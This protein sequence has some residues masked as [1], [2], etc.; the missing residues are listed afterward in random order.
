MRCSIHDAAPTLPIFL[1]AR[2]AFHVSVH[3]FLHGSF[4]LLLVLLLHGEVAAHP[5]FRDLAVSAHVQTNFPRLF[6]FLVSFHELPMF[7]SVHNRSHFQ[8]GEGHEVP[9][10]HVARALFPFSVQSSSPARPDATG[11]QTHPR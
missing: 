3:S 5:P 2:I 1:F 10:L 4:N 7:W 8:Q 11:S 6:L 9:H